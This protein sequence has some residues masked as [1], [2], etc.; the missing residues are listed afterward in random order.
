LSADKPLLR[1]NCGAGDTLRA[2]VDTAGREDVEEEDR[3]ESLGG[4]G[5]TTVVGVGD[6]DP[7]ASLLDEATGAGASV[8]VADGVSNSTGFFRGVACTLVM[9]FAREQ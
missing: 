8:S 5:E 1:A 3:D 7:D 4:G 6:V 2:V 9:S